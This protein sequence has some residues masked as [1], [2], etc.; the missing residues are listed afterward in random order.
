[1][2]LETNFVKYAPITIAGSEIT[3]SCRASFEPPYNKI[4]VTMKLKIESASYFEVRVTKF[5][6]EYGIGIGTR[7]YV[8]TS[9]SP[10]KTEH[11]S[12]DIN[13]DNF[14]YGDTDYRISFYVKSAVDGS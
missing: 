14:K 4:D 5:D 3:E 11:F 2:A 13:E 8:Q 10:T 12:I 7:A 6:E 9:L 1:M